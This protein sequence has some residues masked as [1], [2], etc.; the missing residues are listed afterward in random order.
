[1]AGAAAA[2]AT[3]GRHSA[4]ALPSGEVSAC[5]AADRPGLMQCQAIVK[6]SHAAGRGAGFDGVGF[7]STAAGLPGYGPSS[8][9]SA[10]NLT[11]AASRSGRGETVA[12]V[13]AYRDPDAAAN[14]AR[15]RSYFG[16]PA[17]TTTSR[18]LRIVNEHGKSGPLPRPDA[19]WA[20][21]QSLDLDMV[22]AIC[23]HCRILLVEASSRSTGSL[24]IGEDTAARM[25]ARFVSNSW[26]GPDWLGETADNHYFN[27][28][29]DAIVFASGDAGYGTEYPTDT[30]FVTAVGGT[31]LRH[32]R[33]GK[34]AWTESVWGSADSGVGTGS[35]CA[36]LQAKPSWQREPVDDTAPNGCLNRT[37]NDVAADANPS[38][39]VAIYDSYRTGGTWGVIGGTS[40]ATPIITAAYAL[41]GNPA[42]NTYPASY[43][44]Q[45]ASRLNDVPSG[46]N[47]V[48][49]KNRSYLCHG[50]RG[51]NG[52]AGLGTP[53]GGTAFSGAGT[54]PV[55]LMDPGTLDIEEGTHLRVLISGLDARTAAR[56]LKFSA[57]GLPAGVSVTSAARSTNGVIAGTMPSAPGTYEVAVT[58]TDPRTHRAGTTRF[59][60]VVTVPMTSSLDGEM[61][62]GPLNLCMNASGSAPGT[63]VTLAGCDVTSADDAV[64]YL[65]GGE[66]GGSATMQINNLCVAGTGTKAG[67]PVDLQSC[68]GSAAS[69]WDY[70]LGELVNPASGRCL[71]STGVSGGSLRLAGCANSTDQTWTPPAGDIQSGIASSLCVEGLYGEP[72]SVITGCG[73][74]NDGTWT[75]EPDGLLYSF[76]CLATDGSLD[77]SAVADSDGCDASLDHNSV[78]LPGPGGEIINALSGRCLSDPRNGASGTGLVLEDCYG[79]A[80]QVWTNG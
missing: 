26:S 18:C 50:K 38:T 48:C 67:S 75:A 53:N 40:V 77:S 65:P 47:G 21:E 32:K 1:M 29:G 43:P 20:V 25:G 8:L 64:S 61:R 13:D 51:Y 35:G 49:E 58:A 17:C 5:P 78:W 22:S 71:A 56:S 16:L 11:R 73:A 80:G 72:Q 57:S 19:G 76:G 12:I 66:P 28:P 41:A 62:I 3:V 14:L 9:L 70:S 63:A 2:T 37:E 42:R 31:T 30:Q 60:L 54:D 6:T 15:Y 69:Q 39:G 52:P 59:A 34:R 4:P 36:T 23:P 74:A 55:T 10:Y 46:V 33:S 68:T 45:H 24:G 27:H 79:A 7:A 44:Y